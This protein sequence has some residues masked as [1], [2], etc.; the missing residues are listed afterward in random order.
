MEKFQGYR[1][2]SLPNYLTAL[3]LKYFRLHLFTQLAP[4]TL[5]QIICISE[6]FIGNHQQKVIN[7]SNE[8]L[9]AFS[10]SGVIIM[11]HDE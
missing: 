5:L 3:Q 4:L 2:Y 6:R 9:N 8:H 7:N 11:L 10:S 1:S